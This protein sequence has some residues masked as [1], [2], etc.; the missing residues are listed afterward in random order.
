MVSKELLETLT[1]RELNYY[2]VMNAR[3]GVLF[4]TSAPGYA[5]SAMMLSIANKIGAKYI[6]MRL[7]MA[8][9]TDF[10]FPYR[11]TQLINGENVEVSDFTTPLWAVTANEQLTI[12]HFEELNRAS[13]P[14]RNA[15]LQI[16]LE[17]GIG[18]FK[19]NDN[20]L[21]VASGNKGEEDGTDVEEMDSALYNRIVQID[22]IITPNEWIEQYAKDNVHFTIVDF[23]KQSPEYFYVNPTDQ[24]KSYATPR[25]WTILSE[26]I[27]KNFEGGI[28]APIESFIDFIQ[29]TG[30]GTV[31]TAFTQYSRYLTTLNIIGVNDILNS[32]KKVERAM[33]NGKV[34]NDFLAEI[35]NKLKDEQYRP[36]E[37]TEKQLTNLASFISKC[38]DEL[39]AAY[40]NEVILRVNLQACEKGQFLAKQMK[41]TLKRFREIKLNVGK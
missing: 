10:K 19:F 40:I 26:Q 34:G 38:N 12:I 5:K 2:R 29:V 27:S 25:S 39:V 16:L 3:Y 1:E 33:L 30:P 6:D 28:E 32:P 4:I 8:D 22:H 18:E 20:V 11:R 21:M 15:A 17:R 35:V 14:V 31:G 23:I 37:L 7:A 13:L 36:S 24:Q 41:D 9:E